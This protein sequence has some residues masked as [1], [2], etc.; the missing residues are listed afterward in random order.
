ME[1][2][3]YQVILDKLRSSDVPIQ[4]RMASES[5][6]QLTARQISRAIEQERKRFAPA[7]PT[8]VAMIAEKYEA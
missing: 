7:A 5:T 2:Q 4:I 3:F 1:N 8:Q 6:L